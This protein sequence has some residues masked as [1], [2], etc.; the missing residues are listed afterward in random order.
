MSWNI[1]E[2]IVDGFPQ[3]Y[4]GKIKDLPEILEK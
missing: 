2:M 3:Y 4:Y 1:H